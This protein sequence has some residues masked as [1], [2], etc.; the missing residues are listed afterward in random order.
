MQTGHLKQKNQN[1]DLN[2]TEELQRDLKRAVHEAMLT[3]LCALK[4]CCKDDWPTI[5]HDDVRLIKS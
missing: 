3:N 2:M 4:Q 1:P 5:L